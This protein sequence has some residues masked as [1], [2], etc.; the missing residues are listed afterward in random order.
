M[1]ARVLILSSLL[2]LS[3]CLVLAEEVTAG[4][5]ARTPAPGPGEF[6]APR[7]LVVDPATSRCYII[8]SGLGQ[9]VAVTLDGQQVG[10]WTLE[11]LGVLMPLPADPVLPNPALAVAGKTIYLLNLDRGEREIELVSLS[12]PGASHSVTLPEGASNGALAV[13]SDGRLLVAYMKNTDGTLTL[14]LA[15]ETKNGKCGTI[16]TL[17]DPCEGQVKELTLTGF[18]LA[19]DGRFAIGIAQGGHAAY[20]FIRSWLVQGALRDGAPPD[21]ALEKPLQVTHRFSLLTAQGTVQERFKPAVALAG[22]PGNL[23]KAC[24]PLFTSL[25]IEPDGTIVSGGHTL[26][27]FLRIY[28]KDG[29]M[30]HALPVQ[31]VGGQ[32]LAVL[33]GKNGVRLFTTAPAQHRVLELSADGS[34]QGGFGYTAVAAL[35][36]P[37]A[38]AANANL[39]YVAVRQ[40]AG[41][42]LLC[43]YGDGRFRWA[44]PL[45]PPAKMTGAQ[46]VLVATAN[47]RVFVGWRLPKASGIG[48]VDTVMDDGSP[49]VPLWTDPVMTVANAKYGPCTSPLVTGPT[50]RIYVLREMKEGLRVQAYSA[51]G[52]FLQQFSESVQGITAVTEA[53]N[54][55]WVHAD[56]EGL[57]VVPFTSRG[58]AQGWKRIPR[59]AKGASFF[60]APAGNL[61]GWLSSTNSLLKL[62][63]NLTVVNE[64]TVLDPEG[65]PAETPSAVA[66]DGD[67]KVYLAYPD[68]IYVVKVE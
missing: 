11:A 30:R 3:A 29:T 54:L 44:Q 65:H 32:H 7:A 27:P 39:V 67:G 19:P 5:F 68:A 57:I 31:A 34:P 36:H 63:A 49:G 15:R 24:V 2:M 6:V 4:A 26:D 20:S 23:A 51:T 56:D 46:P 64:M 45:T 62:D 42:G 1:I 17:D 12:G 38:M 14:T 25:A 37:V 40:D 22:K 59:Q 52:A 18:T 61:W 16:G 41:F 48:Y 43:Y 60:P 8:D 28:D 55:A 10:S 35:A 9:V 33:S 13:D 66:G 47:D 21:S 58:D 53:G 50:G